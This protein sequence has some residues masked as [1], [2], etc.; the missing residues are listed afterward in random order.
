ML[1]CNNDR[2]WDRL[3]DLEKTVCKLEQ[4]NE[5]DKKYLY[6]TFEGYLEGIVKSC[7]GNNRLDM[8]VHYQ[9]NEEGSKREYDLLIA[10]PNIILDVRVYLSNS[11]IAH[12]VAYSTEIYSQQNHNNAIYELSMFCTRLGN[13]K[14][15]PYIT[16]VFRAKSE[17]LRLQ[18]IRNFIDY[19]YIEEIKMEVTK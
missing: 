7:V 14:M 2:L 8:S 12:K 16:A 6:K 9:R 19:N 5:S 11:P 13:S 17:E 15:F 1:E 4:K 3:I 18:A 10:L